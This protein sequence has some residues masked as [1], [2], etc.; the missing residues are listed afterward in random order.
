MP[1]P[2]VDLRSIP[3]GATGG[4]VELEWEVPI[5]DGG[6]T[7]SAYH[8]RARPS[9]ASVGDVFA[10]ASVDPLFLVAGCG[11]MVDAGQI[12]ADHTC[13]RVG[14]LDALTSYDFALAASNEAGTGAEVELRASTVQAGQPGPPR[15]VRSAGATGASV[16]IEWDCPLDMGGIW[17]RHYTVSY[18][19][20]HGEPGESRVTVAADALEGSFTLNGLVQNMSVTFRVA[21]DNMPGLFPRSAWSASTI[22]KT[23]LG[24]PPGAPTAVG[25][26]AAT[27]GAASITWHEPA[28]D[29]GFP[30][31]AHHV[32]LGTGAAY[33]LAATIGH[34][35]FL[36]SGGVTLH[37]LAHTTTYS[38][39]VESSNEAGRGGTSAPVTFVTTGITIP[40][41]PTQVVATPSSG[42]SATVSWAL[43]LD[44]GGIA[45]SAYTVFM[46]TDL[47]TARCSTVSQSCTVFG[48]LASTRYTLVVTAANSAGR[49]PPSAAAAVVTK[50]VSVPSRPVAPVPVTVEPCS[51]QGMVLPS[52]NPSG[53]GITF[54]LG[55][56]Q[57]L[58]G[59]AVTEYIL[60]RAN[61]AG[62]FIDVYRGA[63]ATATH[64]GLSPAISYS[65]RQAVR[66]TAGQSAYSLPVALST[67]TSSKPSRLAPPTIVSAT[68]GSICVSWGAPADSGGD[69]V[70]SFTLYR[71]TATTTRTECAD[72]AVLTCR[73][74]ASVAVGAIPARTWCST[75]MIANTVYRFRVAAVNGV[76]NG[77]LSEPLVA[78][79]RP[80]T[81]PT[82]PLRVRVIN[83][84]DDAIEVAW[85]P[86]ADTGGSTS[87]G[88]EVSV[89][90][91]PDPPLS[92]LVD[93]SATQ[94]EIVGLTATTEHTIR[95][96]LIGTASDGSPANGAWS[97]P[98][99]VTTPEPGNVGYSAFTISILELNEADDDHPHVLPLRRLGGQSGALTDTVSVQSATFT[100]A[101][102]NVQP[103]PSDGFSLAGDEPGDGSTVLVTFGDGVGDSQVSL[104]ITNDLVFRAFETIV[105]CISHSSWAP[106]D[107]ETDCVTIHIADDGDAGV[108]GLRTA[109]GAVTED[110][111][112]VELEVYRGSG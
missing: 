26:V 97:L 95:L 61:A 91:S 3:H 54:T 49:S 86:P 76:S 10:Y 67:T 22:V 110:E 85:G 62:A 51:P 96:R 71:A 63:A 75:G 48:L 36:V 56:A 103:L 50:T 82:A 66:N 105:V 106:L 5:D 111:G 31:E 100:D 42:G 13:V 24:V 59:M 11:A 25:V 99:I 18:V 89:S 45:P 47:A 39:A 35:E 94:F 21:A 53:G 77:E 14:G 80:P 8:I 34:A 30:L 43:P 79:T 52:C 112:S 17:V 44:T 4:S 81:P 69:S 38:I 29:G 55:G 33:K 98:L 46:E 16:S 107:A 12:S 90:P 40:S 108:V 109:R 78:S 57:D 101:A 64:T 70:S 72:P 83:A 2:P 28:N 27:G 60:Q 104:S 65:F 37:G 68:G 73:I 15:A 7:I 88:Y 20:Q 9:A 32:Y 1:A 92:T 58:G 19:P 102:G 23:S 41:P 93:K 87:H 74:D 6:G 84:K